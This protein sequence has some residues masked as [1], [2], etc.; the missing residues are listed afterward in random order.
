MEEERV[1][2]PC[3]PTG[4]S[5][6]RADLSMRMIW[7]L[8]SLATCAVAALVAQGLSGRAEAAARPVY[9][10]PFAVAVTPDGATL[11]ATE[12]TAD[13][14]VALSVA[15]G[16]RIWS[17]T[18]PSSPSGLVLSPDGRRAYVAC[19]RA[20]C[21]AVVDL[22]SHKVERKISV[23][24]HPVGLTL[25]GD[26]AT[27]YVC[28]RFTNDVSVVDTKQGKELARVPAVREP[29]YAALSEPTGTLVV[30]NRIANGSNFEPGLAADVT[31]VD[32]ATRTTAG[33]LRLPTG[34]NELEQ[35]VC[36]QDGQWAYV[37][38]VLSRFLVP[39]TQIERGW[40]NTNMLSVIHIPD[41]TLLATVLLDDLDLGAA[42][43]TGALLAPDG[44]TL[45]ISHRGSH[46]ITVLDLPTLHKVVEAVPVEQRADLAND[47]TFLYRNDVRKRYDAGGLGPTGLA[48]SPDG[49]RLFVAN[50]FSD[51]IGVFRTGDMKH[52]DSFP[53][54]APQEMD[55]VRKGE[56]LFH[57]AK[58]CFQQW[59]SCASCH[60]DGRADGLMW[61]LMNDGLGNPKNA[62]SLLLA[63]KT[64]PSMAH[65][66]RADMRVAAEAGVKYILFRQ[67]ETADVDAL[68]AYIAAMEPE[69]SPLLD[70]GKAMQQ[71]IARGKA[72][73]D[74]KE[75][76][77][78]ECH[79]G[80]IYTGLKTV[81]VGTRSKYDTE[82]EFDTPT[83]VELF[84][85]GPYLHDGTAVTLKDVLTTGNRDD[86]HGRTSHLSEQQIE[87][88]ANFLGSL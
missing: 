36:S 69:R 19:T 41:R 13:R 11:L 23:G 81:D 80:P 29:G 55:L 22:K 34:C 50:Y 33:T 40:I 71:S 65:G 10:S 85:T 60:P 20:R 30:T 83:L 6:E 28:N 43:P 24:A 63:G 45:Y 26:G 32:T 82:E 17:V 73:F 57:D 66:I 18:T 70:E 38:G 16:D 84:R 67:P 4:P 25:S 27:L 2:A 78:L 56:F 62:K 77:C 79:P 76:G 68:E 61:D 39:T 74:S 53:L 51:A 49:S 47:L 15:S 52:G 21:V 1:L 35:V 86:K 72:L 12:H 46:E 37:V 5:V 42:N 8:A 64:P 75:T 58:L 59:Q 3:G 48:L 88:L 14:L 87:D 31:F 9:A 54:G 44:E 7:I